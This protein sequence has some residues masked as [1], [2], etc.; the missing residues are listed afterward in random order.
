[1]RTL[2]SSAGGQSNT[3]VNNLLTEVNRLRAQLNQ[4]T[5]TV[6]SLPTDGAT[7]LEDEDIA[8]GTALHHA[9]AARAAIEEPLD[10]GDAGLRSLV[11]ALARRVDSLEQGRP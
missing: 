11:L 3:V 2:Q 5:A 9:R 6:G 10:M 7:V 8:A 1:V 4:L